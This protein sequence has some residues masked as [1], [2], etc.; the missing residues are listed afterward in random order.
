MRKSMKS[1]A[2]WKERGEDEGRF[3][4][5]VKS[6]M[7]GWEYHGDCI[8]CQASSHDICDAESRVGTRAAIVVVGAVFMRGVKRVSR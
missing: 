1:T 8:D 5:H 2:S 4:E 7:F 3:G 6:K